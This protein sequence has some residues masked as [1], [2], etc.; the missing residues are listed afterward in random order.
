MI[1][2]V[3]DALNDELSKADCYLSIV[4]VGGFVLQLHDIKSTLDVD[5]FYED[6]ESI[7]S[8]VWRVGEL[9]HLNQNDE[10]W[11]NCSVANLNARPPE[12]ECSI[13]YDYS[14][15]RVMTTS[16]I[17]VL[18]MKLSSA[19]D[20]DVKDIVSIIKHL[21]LDK[22]ISTFEYLCSLNLHNLDISILLEAFHEAYG[23]EWMQNYLVEHQEE[24]LR[25]Y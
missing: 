16:L 6:N 2:P 23:D 13:L 17:Y 15:L 8:I 10:A 22:P 24:L 20:Q 9:F 4:C 21:K 3:F 14:N 19:R 11:L 5:A 7:R 12:S 18:G 25:Y 1:K